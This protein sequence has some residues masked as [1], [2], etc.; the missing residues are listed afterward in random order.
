MAFS[1][2]LRWPAG[3]PRAKEQVWPSFKASNQTVI[4]DLESVLDALD[5]TNPVVSTN[6]PLRLDGGLRTAQ[7]M[8][9]D[10]TGVALYFTRHGKEVC[11]PCDKFTTVFGN[12]R[13]I[14]LT[15]EYI[16]RMERYGTSEMVDAAFRGFTALPESIIMGPGQSRAWHEVLQVA[17]DADL[18][19]IR[20]AY[21]NLSARYH[22]D[23]KDTGDEAKFA[24][25]QRA[26][27][28]VKDGK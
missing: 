14:G 7:G 10:D 13:A 2:P 25:V 11:I 22:P 28:E 8:T 20:A 27:N 21:R 3:W 26:Y 6:H 23:N 1:N 9:P 12:L 24:E 18:S 4:N 5:A 16:R 15:L 17:S 19:I